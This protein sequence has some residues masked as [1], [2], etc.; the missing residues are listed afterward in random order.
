MKLTNI[1]GTNATGKSTR[2]TNL[3]LALGDNFQEMSYRFLKK[4]KACPEGEDTTVKNIGRYYPDTKT[5]L[6]GKMDKSGKWVGLDTADLNNWD[7]K[8]DFF[9]ACVS[10]QFADI[11]HLVIEGYFNNSS[12][13]GSPNALKEI[14][15]TSADFIVFIYDNV[16]QFRARCEFRTGKEKTMNWAVNSTGWKDNNSYN[17]AYFKYNAEADEN[18]VVEKLN[19]DAPADYLVTKYIKG[20]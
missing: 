20:N 6:L 2:L 18:F 3:A 11:E 9:K 14:G 7:A 8:I 15:I 4:S 12:M 5:F 1:M 10:K 17:N 19:I 13:R 16:E